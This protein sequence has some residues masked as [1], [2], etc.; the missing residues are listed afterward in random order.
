MFINDGRYAHVLCCCLNVGF[1]FP[2][3]PS[4]NI[5]NADSLPDDVIRSRI[6]TTTIIKPAIVVSRNRCVREIEKTKRSVNMTVY[7]MYRMFMKRWWR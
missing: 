2:V 6:H 3:F 4:Q 7:V 5:H 1:P